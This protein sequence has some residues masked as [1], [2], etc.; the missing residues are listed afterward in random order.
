[1]QADIAGAIRV[2]SRARA[3]EWTWAQTDIDRFCLD[4]GWTLLERGDYGRTSLSTDL[5]VNFNRADAYRN[6]RHIR[7]RTGRDESLERVTAYITDL[8]RDVTP[9]LTAALSDHF[10]QLAERLTRDLGSPNHIE[11]KPGAEIGW[12]YPDV[13]IN[14]VTH[15]RCLLLEIVNPRRWKER[16]ADQDSD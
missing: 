5:T 9:A 7:G 11:S 16:R 3:F 8:T 6:R 13:V 15:N 2:V 12:E 1:M 10:D 4:V 14:V